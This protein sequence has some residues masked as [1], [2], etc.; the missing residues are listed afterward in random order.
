MN[1][2]VT[3]QKYRKKPVE[4]EAIRFDSTNQREIAAWMGIVNYDPNARLIHIATLEG[5][6]VAQ[7]GDWII[8]GVKGEFYPCKPAI[9]QATYEEVT[10]G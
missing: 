1:A 2:P 8:R 4:V 3:P 6:M 5:V 10:R 9:F 7:P